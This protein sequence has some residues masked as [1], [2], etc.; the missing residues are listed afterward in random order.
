MQVAE[1]RVSTDQPGRY[2]SQLCKHFAHKLPVELQETTGNIPF[3]F[4]T[5]HL[6]AEAGTLIL[7]CEAPDSESLNRLCDVIANHL[8]RFAWREPPEVNWH[9]V[10]G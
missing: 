2:L 7:R 4:G 3:S 10:Q 5:C 6:R 1:A 8:V 9:P